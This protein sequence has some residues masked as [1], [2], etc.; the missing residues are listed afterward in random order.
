MGRH[1]LKINPSTPE[2]GLEPVNYRP[3][4]LGRDT[5]NA[6]DDCLRL[7]IFDVQITSA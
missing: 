3:R 7:A 6:M 2:T 1:T 4:S 5:R